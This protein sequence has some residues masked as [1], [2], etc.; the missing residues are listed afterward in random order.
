MSLNITFNDIFYT[1]ITAFITVYSELANIIYY[2]K[3]TFMAELP[4]PL[5]VD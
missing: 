4:P 2:L 1:S 3:L 5:Q